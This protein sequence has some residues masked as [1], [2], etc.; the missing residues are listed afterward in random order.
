MRRTDYRTKAWRLWLP[1]GVLA[2]VASPAAIAGLTTQD[3]NTTTPDQLASALAGPGVTI[4]NVQLTGGA[5]VSAG[6]FAGGNDIA[7]GTDK[8]GISDGVVLSSGNV[9]SVVGPNLSGS[10]TTSL[11]LPGDPDLDALVG[12]ATFDA[13]VLEFDFVPSADKVF[14]QYIFASEEYN[15]FVNSTF[16]DVFAFFI[17]GVNCATIGDPR[18]PVSINNINNGNPFGGGGPNAPLYQNNDIASGAPI[19]TEMDG[20]TVALTCEAAVTPNASNH[21][22][23][24]IADT[25]DDRL[26]ANVFVKTGS[27]TT[28]PPVEIQPT[29]SQPII[30]CRG[31]SQCKVSLTCEFATSSGAPCANRV[32]VSVF[33]P[34]RSGSSSDA[35]G[36]SD[37]Q[38]AQARKRVR[39][40]FGIANVPVGETRNVRLKLTKAGRRIAQSSV[41]RLRGVMDIQNVAQTA[42]VRTQVRLRFKRR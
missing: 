27:I 4:S 34:R 3:L 32:D 12:T 33:A 10:T 17:N 41:T 6:V 23:L 9:A 13:T 15:E 37:D 18:V 21:M 35:L 16:N 29:Q 2:A 38:S 25:G 5:P 19:N 24:A 20:L 22:K 28:V 42:V 26:D 40:A 1:I 36:L 11:Q 30:S 7:G 14:F 31:S 39:Y 8:I